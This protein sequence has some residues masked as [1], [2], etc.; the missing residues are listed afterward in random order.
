MMA[1]LRREW[2]AQWR[3]GKM[4]ILGVLFV[5]FGVM[6]PAVAKL[7]PWMLEL[8]GES[9]AASGLVVE[10]VTITA[11]DSWVQFFKNIPMALI[12]FVLML[13]GIFTEEYR[14]GTLILSLTRGASRMKILLS[15]A[16]VLMAMWTMGYWLCFGITYGYNAWYWDN[17][18]AKHLLFSVF[19]WWMRGIWA[20]SL[21]VLFSA[22]ANTSSAVALL[23]GGSFL[24]SYL[25]GLLPKV[26]AW[27]PT[28]LMDGN[29]LI[30]GMADPDG[31]WKAVAIAGVL[32]ML[33]LVL[34][35]PI[36]NKKQL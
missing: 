2:M 10:Q 1:F 21:M 3:T 26:S 18:I 8:M 22:V 27:V 23:T 25:L 6:N 30:Y 19:A 14:C 9:L 12:V 13:G 4:L 28:K 34:A 31:Y 5:V 17:G 16:V 11:L 15:K 24:A 35:V 7:T 29:S 20:V 32:S 36:L 33:A